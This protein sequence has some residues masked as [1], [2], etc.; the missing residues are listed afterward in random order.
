MA[1]P[2]GFAPSRYDQTVRFVPE[3]YSSGSF[4]PARVLRQSASDRRYG[5]RPGRRFRLPGVAAVVTDD[6]VRE[7]ARLIGVMRHEHDR[8]R[9]GA[10]DLPEQ[11]A[12]LAP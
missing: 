7:R 6:P 2:A 12:Q 5:R 9:L 11:P 10:L 8:N 1:L 3:D 4:S